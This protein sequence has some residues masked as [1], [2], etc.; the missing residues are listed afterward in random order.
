MISNWCLMFTCN[1][2][3]WCLFF[4]FVRIMR[5]EM[6]DQVWRLFTIGFILTRYGVKIKVLRQQITFCARK[7]NCVRNFDRDI[8]LNE[9]DNKFCKFYWCPLHLLKLHAKND[10]IMQFDDWRL[11]RR[12]SNSSNGRSENTFTHNFYLLD[13]SWR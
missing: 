6:K 2:F 12:R 11:N 13:I 7:M 10:L 3:E 1:T 5:K 8:R 9:N 4:Y